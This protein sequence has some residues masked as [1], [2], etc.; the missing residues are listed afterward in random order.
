MLLYTE[1]SIDLAQKP[2][3]L[4]AMVKA[5]FFY[6]FIGIESPSPKAQVEAKKFQNLR[7][8]QLE[9]V[10]FIQSEGLWVTAGLI[11]GFDSDTADIFE[12]QIDFIEPPPSPGPWPGFCRRLP[13][14]RFLIEC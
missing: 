1:A 9:S 10:R 7:R 3:L 6:V 8:D 5:N 14:L 13:L 12:Q 4:K 11:V 2:E